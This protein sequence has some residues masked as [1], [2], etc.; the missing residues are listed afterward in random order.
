MTDQLE[1]R[2]DSAQ[3]ASVW[4]TE[5]L[6]GLRD[7]VRQS[8]EAVAQFRSKNNLVSASGDAKI[9]LNDQ[10]MSEM[11]GKLATARAETAEKRAKYEQVQQIIAKSGNIQ[12][13]PDVVRS[14][15]IGEMRKQQAEVARKEADLVARYSDAH[16]SVINAR[17][18]RRDIERSI[19]AEV[20]RILGNLRNDYDV[21]KAREDSLQASITQAIGGSGIDNGVGVKLR[22]LERAN[23]ANKTLFENFLSRTKITQEQSTFQERESRIISPATKPASASFPRLGVIAALGAFF[24]LAFGLGGAVVLEM[25][26]SGFST[27]REVEERLGMP[28]LS[29]VPLLKESARK[30]D[31][32]VVSLPQYLMRKPLSR[33]SEALR[34]IRIGIQMS[35]VDDPAK[36]ILLTSSIPQEGKST[37][38][39]CLAYSATKAGLKVLLIDCDLRHPSVSKYFG[40]ENNPGVV[41]LLTGT[42]TSMDQAL[43]NVEG[44]H[45]IPAG[46]KSQNPPDLLGSERM[47]TLIAKMRANYDLVIID[48]PPVGPVIDARI[49]A[50]FVDKIVFVVRWQE[51]ARDTVAENVVS[52]NHDRR[53][54]GIVLNHVDETMTPK[55]GRYSY[56]SGYYYRKYYQN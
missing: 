20:T 46:T 3:R 17:A 22:E 7:Q 35:D 39:I 34:A 50:Q 26:N 28:V 51:T 29:A 37:T 24:G 56:Y 6:E 47:K 52:L 27:P 30:I 25:L 44:L 15:V 40:F 9:T 23:A 38:S 12:A 41:D 16:P 54:A 2:Y 45:V 21:A 55:Y 14:T 48:S 49:L 10:Q 31:N 4:F 36:T 19:A 42:V 53:I 8:E 32:E 5:R 1:A 11:N 18:E 33:Y 13:I 43:F